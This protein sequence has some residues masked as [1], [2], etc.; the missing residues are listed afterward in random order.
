M[1]IN[2]HCHVFNLQSVFTPGTKKILEN[3]LRALLKDF[4]ILLQP[5]LDFVEV[6]IVNSRAA[7]L[8]TPDDPARLFSETLDR[9]R[10]PEVDELRTALQ[11]TIA[12]LDHRRRFSIAA[13]L[14]DLFSAPASVTL[15][16]IAGF[17]SVGFS[18][19][20]D[21]VTDNLFHAMAKGLE[22]ADIHDDELIIVPLMMDILSENW[23]DYGG[24]VED[25]PDD[26]RDTAEKELAVFETQRQGTTRQCLRHPGRVLPF[27]A[28]NPWRPGWFTDFVKAIEHGGFVGLK[29]YPSLGYLVGDI[30]KALDYCNTHGIPVMTHCNDGGFKNDA[31]Y[32]KLCMPCEWERVLDA[33]K[34]DNLRLCF[35]HCGGDNKFLP[36]AKD[37][38][39]W[40][41]EIKNM[42]SKR[43]GKIYADVSYH[44]VGMGLNWFDKSDYFHMLES[45]L[46]PLDGCYSTQIL[47]GTDY[48]LSMLNLREDEYWPYFA[49]HL[50][51][52]QFD[53]ITS[54]N[55]AAF[56]GLD[57]QHPDNSTE[58]I[59]QHIDWLRRKRDEGLWATDAKPANWL[60][61]AKGF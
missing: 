52:A 60:R 40:L 3:R 10:R 7:T 20:M 49:D 44:T 59:T 46:T 30:A 57:P 18:P 24:E 14:E 17:I 28:V 19:N 1:R 8:S 53:Q 51:P 5:V 54:T 48:F 13:F 25:I 35:G 45:M 29:A 61:N 12:R 23:S 34:L 47:F 37:R 22:S 55:P 38:S 39:K 41:S 32:E 31:G 27:Y 9:Y 36:R 15:L 2:A 11:E 58:N 50:S 33:Y 16:D 21:E 6:I 42:M 43:P 4:A 26:R 56:L